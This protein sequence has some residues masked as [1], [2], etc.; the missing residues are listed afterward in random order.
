MD[1]HDVMSMRKRDLIEL[2]RRD[3]SMVFQSF[4]LL[5]NR[6]VLAN[7]AFGLEVA[8]VSEEELNRKALHALEVVGL[9][10]YAASCP[11][12][13][14]GG[15]TQRVGRA[16]ALSDE[17]TILLMDE[18]VSALDLLIQTEMQDEFLRLRAERG[19]TIVFVSHDL[20]ESC[21]PVIGGSF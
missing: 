20:D 9:E 16:R 8:G 17:P 7:T 19:R 11:D 18:A 12:E 13:L 21:G 2:R 14:S 1:G 10:R 6:T 5:P 15:M 4:A 3:M